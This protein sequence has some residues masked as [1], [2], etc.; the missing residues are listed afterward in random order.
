MAVCDIITLFLFSIVVQ[1]SFAVNN[2]SEIMYVDI[3]L[4]DSLDM[5]ERM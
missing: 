1:Y 5:M 2:C 4:I 3:D